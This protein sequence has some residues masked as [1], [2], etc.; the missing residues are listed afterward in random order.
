MKE[1]TMRAARSNTGLSQEE[2]AK[3]LGVSL[4]AYQRYEREPSL[5]RIGTFLK[6]CRIT[7]WKFIS[8]I[9]LE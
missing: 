9:K 6:F 7:K 2:M 5:M 1:V 3:K 4:S 8:D